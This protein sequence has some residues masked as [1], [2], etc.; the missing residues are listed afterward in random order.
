MENIDSKIQRLQNELE[1]E[2][3]MPTG[4]CVKVANMEME[5]YR[6]YASN[7]DQEKAKSMVMDAQKVLMDPG[8]PPSRQ[9]RMLLNQVQLLGGNQGNQVPY[10]MQ[11]LHFPIYLRYSG[12]IFLGVGYL[13]LFLLNDFDLI[14]FAF[15]NIGIYVVFGLS[16]VFS[17]A[18]RVVFMK[19]YRNR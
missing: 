18:M 10:G 4:N 6:L 14:D 9:K 17:Y 15:Y 19:K 7:G 8:C 12:L 3:M 5:L 13:A 11:R 1:Y 2:K 16:M